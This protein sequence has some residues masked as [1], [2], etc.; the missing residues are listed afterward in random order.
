MKAVAITA[1]ILVALWAVSATYRDYRRQ[2]ERDLAARHAADE[3]REAELRRR[4]SAQ[5]EA[6]RLT[7]AQA[8]K[9]AAAA[10]AATAELRRQQEAAAQ[11]QAAREAEAARWSAELARLRAQKEATLKEAEH[12]SD[13]R[14]QELARIDEAHA[15]ALA[16]LQ[17]LEQEE[18]T[19]RDRAAAL[20]EALEL[21]A[22]KEKQAREAAARFPRGQQRP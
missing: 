14:E 7:A 18:T 11:A 5:V 8:E 1:I 17:A 16:K 2:N 21:Q 10:A 4:E 22:T 19:A 9:E 15:A 13:L 20:A 12:W 3:A 6:N